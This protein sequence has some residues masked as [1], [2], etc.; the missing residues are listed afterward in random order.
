MALVTGSVAPRLRGSFMSFNASIQQLGAGVASLVAGLVIGRAAD[1]T[2]TRFGWVGWC[3][4]ACTLVAIVLAPHPHRRPTAV[5]ARASD[6]G[7]TPRL[8]SAPAEWH[9]PAPSAPRPDRAPR[10]PPMIIPSLLD[11]DL[12]KFTMMQVVLHHFAEAQVEY[13]FKCRNPGVDLTPYVAEIEDEIRA[14]C[15]VALH[16]ARARLPAALALLQERLRR[17]AGPVPAGPA[18]HHRSRGARTRRARSTSRS[19]ARG[20]TRSCSRCR[21]SRSCPRCTTGTRV[22]APDLA[23]GRRRLARQDRAGERRAGKRLPHRRLRHAPA[24]LARVARRGDPHA[25]GRHGGALRRHQQR[26]VRASTTA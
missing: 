19:R 12:Y 14:L 13:R 23:E 26:Q 5:A 3:A 17:P 2:L 18:L 1:G 7:S 15:D 21:C 16:G 22:P 4:V 8:A 9:G 10:S 11:T 24:L 20:C 6:S 25:E